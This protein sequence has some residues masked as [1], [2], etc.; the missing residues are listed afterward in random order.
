VAAQAADVQF[1]QLLDFPV[2]ETNTCD[3]SESFARVHPAASRHAIWA[4]IREI[5]YKP[6]LLKD[7]SVN[8]GEGVPDVD[9][10]LQRMMKTTGQVAGWRGCSP[11]P[12]RPG[13]AATSG[14]GNAPL[15]QTL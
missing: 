13:S 8:V 12:R 7:W 9:F 1:A 14:A 11:D 5:G 6:A 10:A 2:L 15:G 3:C 4:S